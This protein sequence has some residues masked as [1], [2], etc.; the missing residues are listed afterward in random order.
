MV[1]SK[2]HTTRRT[3]AL[4]AGVVPPSG[5]PLPQRTVGVGVWAGTAAELRNPQVRAELLRLSEIRRELR[6]GRL[7]KAAKIA[8]QV[9]VDALPDHLETRRSV[10]VLR[11]VGAAHTEDPQQAER[12]LG[13]SMSILGEGAPSSLLDILLGSGSRLSSEAVEHSW[14]RE[15]TDAAASGRLRAL[16][17]R[18]AARD[19]VAEP[20]SGQLA[21]LERRVEEMLALAMHRQLR[22]WA[23]VIRSAARA[24][25]GDKTLAM[26][27]ALGPNLAL[28]NPDNA[29]LYRK[30]ED[31]FD[32]RGLSGQTKLVLRRLS[33]SAWSTLRSVL[34][35]AQP[36]ELVSFSAQA[37]ALRQVFE[38]LLARALLELFEDSRA[39]AAVRD[40]PLLKAVEENSTTIGLGR[41]FALLFSRQAGRRDR[42][43]TALQGWFEDEA[44]VAGLRD[45]DILRSGLG[46]LLRVRLNALPHDEQA[47]R[48]GASELLAVVA[49]VGF[50]AS[51]PDSLPRPM[52]GLV[53]RLNEVLS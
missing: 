25:D 7:Q 52:E 45:G 44:R 11:A 9:Q 17:A 19:W 43:A 13:E 27:E 8:L 12:Y 23:E 47:A 21:E 40:H 1:V 16:L 32:A 18:R 5:F 41:W 26:I 46:D 22:R 31:C 30:L 37:A 35:G 2:L 48:A 4:V 15:A 28:T 34:F 51:G 29:S 49:T 10:T 50:G 38:V 33:F 6:Y 14:P 42:L 53:G 3:G 24:D 39:A 36:A 20:S